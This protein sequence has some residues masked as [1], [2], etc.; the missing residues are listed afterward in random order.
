MWIITL[1]LDYIP[2]CHGKYNNFV[3]AFV[4]FHK[5]N[6]KKFIKRQKNKLWQHDWFC[7]ISDLW[8]FNKL[9]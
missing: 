6:D 3:H 5:G 8:Y 2:T 9:I 1:L 4:N 7:H